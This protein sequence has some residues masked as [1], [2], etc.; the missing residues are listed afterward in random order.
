MAHMIL[1]DRFAHRNAPGW[2][3]IARKTWAPDETITATEAAVEVAGDVHVEKYPLYYRRNENGIHV[4]SKSA[5][6]VIVRRPLPDDD[7]WLEL[8]TTGDR[9]TAASYKQL[10]G[11][12]DGMAY[13]IETAGLLKQGGL[14]FLCFR[15]P[16]WAV[17]GDEM[18]SYFAANFSLTPGVGHK[19]FH[20][21]IRVVCWN[22]NTVAENQATINLSIPHTPDA[23][24]RIKL[25]ADLAMQF[26]SVRNKTKEV[27]ESFA[28][29]HITEKEAGIIFR[30]AFP[31]PA[32]P[33]KL[34]LLKQTL[35]STE[36]ETFKQAMTPDLLMGLQKEEEKYERKVQTVAALM[37]ASRE[38]FEVFEPANMRGTAWAAYN[39]VTEVSD[40]REGRG[41]DESLVMGKRA[42]EKARA[43][44]A[45]SKLVTA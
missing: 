38:R 25:A 34:R 19:V 23:L 26:E 41:A 14:M 16:D 5:Q 37:E 27:F 24:Q 8:G 45:A 22:T 13:P 32:L 12:L 9:W 39:A 44:S 42:G 7:K 43:Y 10:A 31:E 18:R 2:H 36:A 29:Y 20:S 1:G 11:A 33:A 4:E 15:A 30:A 28:G 6:S 17:K 35:S 21:P 3:N 40:W